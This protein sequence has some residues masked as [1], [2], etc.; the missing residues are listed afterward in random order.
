ML[1]CRITYTCFV[2]LQCLNPYRF[3]SGFRIG[4]PMPRAIGQ[5]RKTRQSGSAISGIPS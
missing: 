3:S 1:S 5:S 4:N 2:R